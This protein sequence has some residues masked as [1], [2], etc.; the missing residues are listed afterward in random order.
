LAAP[1]REQRVLARPGVARCLLEPTAPRIDHTRHVE[2][3]PTRR[4]SGTTRRRDTATYRP[5]DSS[6]SWGVKDGRGLPP[7]GPSARTTSN[8]L[9]FSVY[10]VLRHGDDVQL[11][12]TDWSA[13]VR[14][15]RRAAKNPRGRRSHRAGSK[16]AAPRGGVG[17][18]ARRKRA[19]PPYVAALLLGAPVPEGVAGASAGR[20]VLVWSQSQRSERGSNVHLDLQVPPTPSVV[21]HVRE[22]FRALALSPALLDDALQLVTELVTN[23]IRHAGLGSHDRIRVRAAW[24][25]G[26]LRVDVS[27][28]VGGPVPHPVAGA[29]RPAPG[30]ESGWGLFL[31]DRLASRWGRGQGHFWFELELQGPPKP[32]ED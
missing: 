11:A 22:A 3:G 1:G 8:M 6:D 26:R 32:R 31:V 14:S 16:R 4:R 13:G 5:P 27:D 23:S 7:V 29:I 19:E 30:G 25:G 9:V 12:D 28:R 18:T 20:I 2:H 24:S 17:S 15:P 21:A 10:L